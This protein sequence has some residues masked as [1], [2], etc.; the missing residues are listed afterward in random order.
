MKFLMLKRQ[1]D[2]REGFIV[3]NLDA[4]TACRTSTEADTKMAF[5][6][7]KRKASSYHIPFEFSKDS[8]QLFRRNISSQ[9][10]E[11]ELSIVLPLQFDDDDVKGMQSNHF[12]IDEMERCLLDRITI[13]VF[14]GAVVITCRRKCRKDECKSVIIS[15]VEAVVSILKNRQ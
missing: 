4:I 14:H 5:D 1:C 8:M 9:W 10:V 6:A 12:L 13:D 7:F 3:K 15:C 11:I 2:L